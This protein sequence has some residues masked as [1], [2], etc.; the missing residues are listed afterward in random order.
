VVEIINY[1]LALLTG[2]LLKRF[3]KK[4]SCGCRP[5]DLDYYWEER[6]NFLKIEIKLLVP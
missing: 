4:V 3:L 5:M 1:P 2:I 6:P